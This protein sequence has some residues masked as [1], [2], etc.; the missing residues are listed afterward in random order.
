MKLYPTF[1]FIFICMSN[2]CQR[3]L[4]SYLQLL[5]IDLL[6][7]QI[8][9]ILTG[10]SL[11]NDDGNP[12]RIERSISASSA[13]QEIC[14]VNFT[15]LI[16]D[17]MR[18]DLENKRE[19]EIKQEEL[20]FKQTTIA[21]ETFFGGDVPKGLSFELFDSSNNPKHFNFL[22]PLKAVLAYSHIDLEW[23]KRF[24]IS[25]KCGGTLRKHLFINALK[26]QSEFWINYLWDT[27]YSKKVIK[28]N[29]PNMG[30]LRMAIGT[31]NH[32]QYTHIYAALSKVYNDKIEQRKAAKT[33]HPNRY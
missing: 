24:V 2:A 17:R 4:V 22:L 1:A 15:Q 27:K 33:W 19:R 9:Y 31:A 20:C 13:I 26:Y 28:G 16:V 3:P 10:K 29:I 5:P 7:T 8:N 6:K 25:K 18:I 30:F 14:G 21:L 12:T 32:P 23:L 11:W